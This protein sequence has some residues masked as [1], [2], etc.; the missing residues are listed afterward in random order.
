[1]ENLNERDG[2]GISWLAYSPTVKIESFPS[3]SHPTFNGLQSIMF[4]NI[5]LF[6]IKC[7]FELKKDAIQFIALKLKYVLLTIFL[8]KNDETGMNMLAVTYWRFW[9]KSSPFHRFVMSGAV[10]PKSNGRV[11]VS[12]AYTLY[13]WI[14]ISVW[15]V[16][17]IIYSVLIPNIQHLKQWITETA[18]SHCWCSWSSVA[19]NGIPLRCLQSHQ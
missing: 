4:Q 8:L 3:E 9:C 13:S 1:V 6:S 16:K 2:K 5:G 15:Y 7:S 18:A 14:S 19:G 17:Q 11:S 12:H 10:C